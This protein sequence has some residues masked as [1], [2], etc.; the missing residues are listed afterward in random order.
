MHKRSYAVMFGVVA[1]ELVGFGLII[2]VLPQISQQ[3]TSSGVLL[4]L[5]IAS[6]S[7]A[8]FVGAP[9][10]GRWSDHVGR[11]PVLIISKIGTIVSYGI[12][13][14]SHQ[15]WML[16]VSRIID[17]LT[18]GNIAVARAYLA[19]ITP[20][21]QRSRAMAL[22]G[23]A[24]GVGF[25][26]G[27][28][29]GAFCY[30]ISADFSVAG[31]VGAA[32]SLLSLIVTLTLVKEPDR[33][34]PITRVSLYHQWRGLNTYAYG[35][36]IAAFAGMFL[37]SAFES[38]FAVFTSQKF[39][40]SEVE[41]SYLFAAIGIAAFVIQGSFVRFSISPITRALRVAF[42]SIGIG[43]TLSVLFSHPLASM[44][45][46]ILVLFGVAILNTHVP[47]AL[48]SDTDSAGFSMGIY[49]SINSMARIMGP[50]IVFSVFYAHII[51][52]YMYMGIGAFSAMIFLQWIVTNSPDQHHHADAANPT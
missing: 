21:K 41:N 52:V 20:A 12:L 39:G 32:M 8:Q 31:M 44:G 6:Y 46:L 5:L 13:A 15:Y 26:L 45:S 29:L 47:A 25:I 16:L 35:L 42:F 34:R 18:G 43:L 1:T 51:R 23:I 7:L 11:K 36:L 3:Y 24:F 17:G 9:F 49:E 28:I 4:G 33:I 48:A 50:L 14:I 30:R 38:S 27:P 37:F 22:I 2:P 10:L 19:D 40:Y